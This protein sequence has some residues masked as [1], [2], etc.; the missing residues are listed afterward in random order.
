MHM[1]FQIGLVLSVFVSI[2]AL[3]HQDYVYRPD[4]S[5]KELGYFSSKEKADL[6]SFLHESV[7]D[8]KKNSEQWSCV[9]RSNSGE[10]PMESDRDKYQLFQSVVESFEQ[11]VKDNDFM[12]VATSKLIYSNDIHASTLGEG[13]YHDRYEFNVLSAYDKRPENVY[14]FT[15]IHVL[16][17]NAEDIDI[18]QR[19]YSCQ[20]ER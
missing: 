14:G 17:S 6:L 9:K 7:V 3:A 18:V 4:P 2:S 5:M 1:K 11:A 16:R 12:S 20:R 15:I 19:V 13:Y 8:A 10:F